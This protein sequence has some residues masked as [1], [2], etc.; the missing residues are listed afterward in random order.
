MDRRGGWEGRIMEAIGQYDCNQ[1]NAEMQ[2]V[3]NGKNYD[4]ESSIG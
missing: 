4:F 1:I 3:E 2:K